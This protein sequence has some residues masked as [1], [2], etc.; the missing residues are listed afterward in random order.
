[1]EVEGQIKVESLLDTASRSSGVRWSGDFYV[2]IRKI[3]C[4]A[5]VVHQNEF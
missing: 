2:T 3:Y 1:M 5:N 4:Q